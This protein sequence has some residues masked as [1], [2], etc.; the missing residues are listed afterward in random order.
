MAIK[1][2]EKMVNNVNLA[3]QNETYIYIARRA[4]ASDAII[5]WDNKYPI[6]WSKYQIKETDMRVKTANFTTNQYLD[7][8]TGQYNV[9]ITSPYHEDFGGVIISVEYDDS[10]GLYNY[11]CQ[12]FSRVYQGKFEMISSKV[13][14]HR[15]LQ[16]LITRGAI[17]LTGNVKQK[18]KQYKKS[19]SGLRP[20]WQYWE[21]A[22]GGTMDY[23]P[24]TVKKNIIIRNKSYIEAIRDIVFGLGLFIDVYFDKYGII[25]IEPFV[26]DEWL[27]TG[28]YITTPEIASV[29]HKF[30]T[31]NVIT[32][33]L[34]HNADKTKLG[35]YYDASNLVN[36]NL[37]LFFGNL[38]ASIDNPDSTTVKQS[39]TTTLKKSNTSKVKKNTNVYN[40]KKKVVYLNIDNIDGHSSDMNKMKTMKKLLNKEGWQVEIMGVGPSTHYNR[41]GE[42]KNGIWFC[43]YGGFCAGTLREAC[44]NNWYL[45]PIKK[46][47]SR[48]VIGFFPPATNG[49]LKGGKYYKHLGP[50]WDWQGSS[51]YANLNYPTKFMSSNGVPFMFGKNAKEMVAKFLAGGDNFKTEGNSYKYY[52]S[53]QKKKLNWL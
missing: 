30:D 2:T 50:A 21:R 31:T 47:K 41:R 8:T 20:A 13:T 49:I 40:T 36:L 3:K 34:V 29:K 15:I 6:Q 52:G 46:N 32:G 9:L 14:I 45:N 17:P 19:L 37:S 1:K 12:D 25:H 33:T 4:I 39:N 24:M 48:V 26:K 7:L 53:W 10:T 18:M 44:E 23:N 5:S 16:N 51:S 35:N 38:S 11:Q 22:W 43:L 42:V 27:N 28:L